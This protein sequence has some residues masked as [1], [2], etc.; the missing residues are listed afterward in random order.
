MQGLL[1]LHCFQNIPLPFFYRQYFLIHQNGIL[2][3]FKMLNYQCKTCGKQYNRWQLPADRICKDALCSGLGITG[4]IVPVERD[5]TGD[6]GWV[7]PGKK[8]GT[9]ILTG[10]VLAGLGGGLWYALKHNARLPVVSETVTVD[11][12]TIVK[13]YENA[14][15]LLASGIQQLSHKQFDSALITFKQLAKTD[16][17]NG[18]YFMGETY[19]SVGETDSA[20]LFFGKAEEQNHPLAIYYNSLRFDKDSLPEIIEYFKSNAAKGDVSAMRELGKVYFSF[21]SNYKEG[22]YWYNKAADMDDI[23]SQLFVSDYYYNWRPKLALKYLRMCA[24]HNNPDCLFKLGLLLER[25]KPDSAYF[26]F[27]AAA[28]LGHEEAAEKMNEMFKQQ[29]LRF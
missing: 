27:N 6:T 26:Y 2:I 5:S 9:G 13:S 19:K 21:Y 8:I 29:V 20:K 4:L 11:T 3:H 28:A 17:G 23:Q 12:T 14:D 24:A 10:V 15:S 18:Y 1:Y 22:L 25:S 16:T 7:F